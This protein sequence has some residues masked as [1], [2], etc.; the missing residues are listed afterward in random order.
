MARAPHVAAVVSLVFALSACSGSGP[1]GP[2]PVQTTTPN[3]NPT[4]GTPPT[5]TPPPTLSIGTI[6]LVSVSPDPGA[7]LA[8]QRCVVNGLPRDC[9]AWSGAFEV[10]LA[11][12]IRWP[13]L[14]VSF[15][16]GTTLCGY[17]A[18]TVGAALPAGVPTTFQPSSISLTDEWG[19][20]K[21]PCPLPAKATRLVAELWTDDN[22]NFSVK[23]EFSLH[24][25]F[26]KP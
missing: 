19:T 20:F 1:T 3:L 6:K 18:A 8:V 14:T 5:P 25:T 24:Y 16:D 10:T 4:V 21:T 12:E 7:A 9:A 17:A 13:V 26:V 22:W 2:G 23:Q 15:Y 11:G